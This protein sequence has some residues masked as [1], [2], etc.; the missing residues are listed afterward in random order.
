[1]QRGG[2]GRLLVFVQLSSK[3]TVE[4][5]HQDGSFAEKQQSHPALL[6]LVQGQRGGCASETTLAVACPFAHPA[7]VRIV[8]QTLVTVEAGMARIDGVTRRLHPDAARRTWA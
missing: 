1:M 8:V 7:L 3:R 5:V 6:F 4:P 2:A